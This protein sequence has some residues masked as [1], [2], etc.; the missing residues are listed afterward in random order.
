MTVLMASALKLFADRL[1]QRE[2][3]KA[4][5]KTVDEIMQKAFVDLDT[6]TNGVKLT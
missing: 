6:A 4:T 3:N 5:I 2:S 1:E